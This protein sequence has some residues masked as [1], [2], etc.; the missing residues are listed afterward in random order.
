[1]TIAVTT[2]PERE[3]CSISAHSTFL[4][5][6]FFVLSAL[7]PSV[8]AEIITT[9]DPESGLTTWKL[10]EDG[11][12]LELIQRL[13]DQTRAFFQ[14]RGFSNQIADEIGK[15]CVFQ[16]I[17]R[18]SLNEKAGEAVTISLKQWQV[19]IGDSIQGIKL[20]ESW[21]KEWSDTQVGNASR[22]AFR[23]ATFPTEQTFEPSGDYNWGMISFGLPPASIF[24]LNVVW[25]QGQK[26]K[27]L[28]INGIQCPEDR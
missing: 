14:G 4:P 27:N 13:P 6:L 16:T 5:I 15:N 25:I 3:A 11:F 23:W 10:S 8:C 22:I 24:D 20:K 18:N 26:E 9:S 7:P 2:R 1:M 12:E 17:G 28:W 19:R 21:D